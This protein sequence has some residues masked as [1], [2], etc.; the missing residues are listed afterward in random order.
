MEVILVLE[1]QF[2]RML[3]ELF[4]QAK[5]III[6][7]DRSGKILFMN[8]KASAELQLS[9]TK[10]DYLQVTDNS[11]SEYRNFMYNI[12][13]EMTASCSISIYNDEIQELS[14]KLIGYL[15]EE[16]NMIFCRVLMKQEYEL[17]KINTIKP[18]SFEQLIN[19][20]AHG[21]VLTALN[22][23][24]ISAN[25]KALQLINREYWQIEKRSY[26]C[27]FEECSFDSSLIPDYY[28]K[29]A[30]N[31]LSNFI[32]KKIDSIGNAIYL[33]FISKI[34]EALGI[35]I[36]TII[37]YTETV[38]LK[39]KIE[40]QQTLSLLGQ[41]V[42]TI[43][44]EI[45]NPMTSIQGFIQMIKSNSSEK[46][47]PYFH[48][49]ETELQRID[50]LLVDLLNFSKPKKKEL[51]YVNLQLLT[52]Q[53]IELMQPK[54]VLSNSIVVF[55]HEENE[56]YLLYGNENRLKQLIINLL[57]N[58]LES[59][60]SANYITVQLRV[61]EKNCIQ[62]SITD[63]GRGM[64]KTMVES[65]FNPFYS[66]KESGTGLGLMLV[67]SIVNEHNGTIHIESEKGKG[68]KFTIDFEFANTHIGGLG[69]IENHNHFRSI[70]SKVTFL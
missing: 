15:V 33:N 57:K 50:E 23:K 7:L 44:H 66:T 36:T 21:V 49:V 39:E 9:N 30:N 52:E 22:G 60:D 25:S 18:I 26:D 24:I 38:L 64:D 29:I 56:S 43:A 28:K 5:E 68:T 59:N 42:A 51:T 46:E 62:I 17:T 37:D 61:K 27:L 70:E 32:V 34:D 11:K 53:V 41:N 14:I 20:M 47:H 19:G 40:H 2:I 35:L 6:V 16:K 3:E 31:Q 12:E 45:R 8:S 65:V 4:Q 58:A 13:K 55:E 54:V 10:S 1:T 48:I 67:Q 63:Q 69:E